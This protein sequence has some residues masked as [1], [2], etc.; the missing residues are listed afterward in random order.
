MSARLRLL[1]SL[2]SLLACSAAH[3]DT[4]EC[5]DKLR[6]LF[7]DRSLPPYL[8]GEGP[9]LQNPPGLFFE[10]TQQTLQQLG[11]KAELVRVPQRRLVS[12]TA[13]GLAEIT[14]YLAYTPERARQLVFPLRADNHGPNPNLALGAAQLLLYARKD[15][16]HAIHWDGQVLG[17][18][19][20]VVGVVGGG[21]EEP[22]AR[23]FGWQLDPSLN[24]A[25]SIAKL[26]RGH[27]AVALIPSFSFTPETLVAPP[28]LVALQPAL[29]DIWF[30][31]PVNPSFRARHPTFVNAFWQRLCE[32]S[33]ERNPLVGVTLPPCPRI[34]G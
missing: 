25:T 31:A 32:V 28:A 2:L 27:V 29:Q 23:Q 22:L 13:Q 8:M 10:W 15:R 20:L 34:G 16:S 21:V 33:R 24:H 1:A 6:I 7:L 14:L 30:Y 18:S 17:P 9:G 11:C 26:R 12:E 4:P 19:G 3:A 5:P